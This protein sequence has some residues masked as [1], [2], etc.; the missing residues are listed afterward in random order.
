MS[1]PK[2]KTEKRVHSYSFLKRDNMI[3]EK[4]KSYVVCSNYMSELNEVVIYFLDTQEDGIIYN[5]IYRCLLDSRGNIYT[6][7]LESKPQIIFKKDF[8][9]L[10][11]IVSEFPVFTTTRLPD[12]M[13]R[14]E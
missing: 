5:I 6:S 14:M 4:G 3:P 1:K 9:K 12:D 8:Y 11:T 7:S 13:F 2:E 10:W